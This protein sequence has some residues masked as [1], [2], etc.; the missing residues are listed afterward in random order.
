MSANTARVVEW[1]DV[2]PP[3]VLARAKPDRRY[4]GIVSG[5]AGSIRLTVCKGASEVVFMG[6]E[7]LLEFAPQVAAFLAEVTR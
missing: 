4:V 3:W 1:T 7:D 5:I 6:A 2:T